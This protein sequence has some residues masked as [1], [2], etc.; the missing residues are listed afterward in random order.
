MAAVPST[1]RP[2]ALTSVSPTRVDLKDVQTPELVVA[3]CGPIGS[4]VHDVAEKLKALL[5]GGHAY[6]CRIIRLSKFIDLLAEPPPPRETKYDRF[7]RL[8]DGGNAL[9]EKYGASVLADLAIREIAG[10]REQR[11]AEAGI[12]T[13]S[14]KRI[15]HIID[16]IKNKEELL[17]LRL[18]YRDVM[19]LVG[20]YASIDARAAYLKNLPM[21]MSDVYKL[22]DRDSGEEKD[23]GQTVREIF[24]RSDYFLRADGDS[25][26]LIEAKLTRFLGLLFGLKVTTPTSDESAMYHAAAAARASACLSRQ[27][28]AAIVDAEG[29]LLSVGWNDVPRFGGGV[30][31]T[32]D[33]L[34]GGA[35]DRRCHN[36]RSRCENDFERKEL[37]ERVIDLV[38]S[39]GEWKG[40]SKDEMVQA[41]LEH[42][43]G[44]L[45]EFSR[46]VHAEMLAVLSAKKPLAG[47]T[48]YC[49][50]YPCH[51]CARHLVAAGIKRV[52]YIEPY[53]KS[54]AVKLHSDS[55][56]EN[57]TDG[58]RLAILPYEGVAP[59]RYLDLFG[60][61]PEAPRK[62]VQG[63]VSVRRPAEAGPKGEATLESLPVLEAL[64]VNKL[65]DRAV[66]TVGAAAGGTRA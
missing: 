43:V 39:L 64:I 55:I 4:P 13:Y 12:E 53:R 51:S 50:T 54:L 46:A 11:R 52:R 65:K 37:A 29:A 7:K 33:A 16:S 36:F 45:I 5:E 6:E 58:D 38:L 42:S 9:R 24:P 27:V 63:G 66:P 21:E 49:T 18:V 22:I 20:V 25:A 41:V 62:D 59:G 34:D 57:E 28:G 17:T 1:A 32:K 56:C 48:L 10:D 30:Y 26:A 61:T 14:P 8:I 40:P 2:P 35:A 60:V 31:V 15:C 47:A 3:L 19:C 44:Y 23:H